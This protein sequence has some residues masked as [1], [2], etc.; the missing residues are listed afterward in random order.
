MPLGERAA[1]RMDPPDKI[2]ESIANEAFFP[3]TPEWNPMKLAD[4]FIVTLC[5]CVIMARTATRTGLG[6]M[7][8]IWAGVLFG[9]FYLFHF[10]EAAERGLWTYA[11]NFF[12]GFVMIVTGA[13]AAFRE[14][15][16][17]RGGAMSDCCAV[18]F[19]YPFAIMQIEHESVELALAGKLTTKEPEKEP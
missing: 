7:A 18:F 14:E 4:F 1:Q 5:P 17:F 9:L 11:W 13:R 3:W 12:F 15:Y 2:R 16:R 19:C 10:L 6:M 8:A